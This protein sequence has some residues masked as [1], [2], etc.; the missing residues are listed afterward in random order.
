MSQSKSSTGRWKQVATEHGGSRGSSRVW[1]RLLGH[2]CTCRHL[3]HGGCWPPGLWSHRPTF[4]GLPATMF[5]CSLC[6][7]LLQARGWPTRLRTWEQIPAK[8]SCDS[9]CRASP[10]CSCTSSRREPL[11]KLPDAQRHSLGA[12]H[13]FV[14]LCT[15]L[16]QNSQHQVMLNY[17][18]P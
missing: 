8:F 2:P 14:L 13:S 12:Q 16:E 5:T 3:L 10:L 15:K 17:A 6:F 11:L 1:P 9:Q 7:Q 4:Q 18:S